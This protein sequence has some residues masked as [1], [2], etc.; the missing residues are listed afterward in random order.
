M[1]RRK[2]LKTATE[3]LGAFGL[4][5]HALDHRSAWAATSKAGTGLP[6]DS[7]IYLNQIGYFPSRS[8]AA[9]V[10]ARASSFLVQSATQNTV[11]FRADLQAPRL[12]A[13]SGDRVQVADFSALKTPGEYRL[14]LDTGAFSDPFSIGEDIY[15]HALWLT[16]RAFYGQRCGC[17]VN[18][19]GGYTHPKCHLHAAYHPSS[20]KKGQLKNHGGWHDAGDYGRYIVNSGITTGTLLWAWEMYGPV[21][22]NLSLQIPESGGSVPD[23]LTEIQW[24]LQWMLTLQDQDGGVWQKQ[25]SEQFCPFVMPQD[26][27]AISYVIGTGAAP[28]KSTCATADFAAV[29]AIAARC[30]SLCAPKFAHQCL[31][32]A[33]KAWAWCQKYPDVEFLNP[34]GIGTGQYE[35]SDCQDEI[36][37][38]AAELWRTTGEETFNRAF[39]AM[40]PQSLESLL[41]EVPAWNTVSPLA[42]WSY[43]LAGE[44]SPDATVTAVQ[45]ATLKTA[46]RLLHQSAENGYGN[47]LSLANYT[48]GSNGTAANQSL[49]LLMA[50]HFQPDP[51]L[52]DGALNNLHYLLGRNCL[53]ISWITQLGA[54]PFQHPHHRPSVA[55]HITAPWPGLMSGGPNAHPADRVAIQQPQQPPMRMYVDND[56]AY[57]MNEVAINW[58]APL[59]FLLAAAHSLRT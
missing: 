26:D 15:A 14:Q 35:D 53:G 31:E 24:N 5:V 58:N 50:N 41:I 40:I 19:G 42:Y 17:E 13:A 45:Q 43:A 10:R 7:G 21:L 34:S 22:N 4:G 8:K 2:F 28:Y 49:L 30:Y 46:Q 59:V 25:T 11:V 33:R 54:R 6:T 57:S 51:A 48:W 52:V 55:D 36:L 20:G 44:K 9:T 23:F 3:C 38:A 56:Q 39:L 32:S 18:L 27:H 1:N 16:M 12:D 47:T 37:W 29:M